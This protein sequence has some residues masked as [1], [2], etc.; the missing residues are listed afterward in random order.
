MER[1]L[2]GPNIDMFL[3]FSKNWIAIGSFDRKQ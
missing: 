2:F 3:L 1:V